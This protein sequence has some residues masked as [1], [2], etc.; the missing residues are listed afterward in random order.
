[1]YILP[2]LCV[3]LW[4]VSGRSSWIVN[5]IICKDISHS[6]EFSPLTQLWYRERRRTSLTTKW[7]GALQSVIDCRSTKR[8]T[9]KPESLPRVSSDSLYLSTL[10]SETEGST[11]FF[12][13]EDRSKQLQWAYGSRKHDISK[14]RKWKLHRWLQRNRDVWLAENVTSSP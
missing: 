1:M 2:Y 11:C 5:V 10:R 14:G 4:V 9:R 3:S 8:L 13:S 7:I 12:K 6:C